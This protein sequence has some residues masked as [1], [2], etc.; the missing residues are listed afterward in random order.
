M[1]SGMG[2]IGVQIIIR[3]FFEK[4]F[5]KKEY[6]G[7]NCKTLLVIKT[8]KKNWFVALVLV[9]LAVSVSSISVGANPCP[10]DEVTVQ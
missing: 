4:S 1:S 3:F 5:K 7:Q 9:V 2:G 8:M 6:I 10:V